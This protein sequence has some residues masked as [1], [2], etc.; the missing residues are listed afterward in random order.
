MSNPRIPYQFS[1]DG[2][3]L[4]VPDGRSILV[5][6]VVNVE[7][8]D[9]NAAMPRTLITAPHGKTTI[10][11][12]P[13]YGWAEYGMRAGLPRMINAIAAR[14]LKAS[15]SCNASVIDSHPR[16]AEAMLEAG[17]EFIGH[18]YSQQVLQ[19]E[20]EVEVITTSLK[21]LRDFTGKQPRGWLSPGLRSTAQTPDVLA[22][23]GV[24]Y[25]CD[26]SLDD[27][28]NWM[29]VKRGSLLQVPYNLE[30]NDSIIFAIE[31]HTSTEYL[32][33]LRSTLSVFQ[34]EAA[35]GPRVLALGL[36]PHLVGVPHRFEYF[37][38][39]L[40]VLQAHPLVTFMTGSD[41]FD[42]YSN[43]VPCPFNETQ[44]AGAAP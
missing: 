21:K 5:H 26:W 31:K 7:T 41:I 22:Q 3:R 44:A 1:D 23:A 27:V 32:T 6:L 40:D 29:K 13:N 20:S 11:D 16:A 15:A 9:F 38:E 42:W 12:V 39:M 4:H 25:L 18:G 28:P 43:Q 8:W 37:E 2:P 17:W 34:K 30:M 33:R 36:H 24:D 19:E 35:A 10:P 14:G